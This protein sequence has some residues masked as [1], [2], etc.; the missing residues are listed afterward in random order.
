LPNASFGLRALDVH[1][2]PSSVLMQ[3]SA[4]RTGLLAGARDTRDVRDVGRQLRITGR[5]V[6]R[7][8]ADTTSNVSRGSPP[9]R[10]SRR[11]STLGHEMLTST[12]AT[13]GAPSRMPLTSAYSCTVSAADV[14]QH[15][16]VVRGQRGADV[17]YERAHADALE[18]DRVQEP[19]G[20]LRRIRGV[21]QPSR[22]SR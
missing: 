22:G 1:R 4:S 20:R 13:P 9:E 14:H 21:A 19:G 18:P 7:R 3:E 12:P 16:G 8:T 11:V 5:R 10:D 2:R 15:G 17:A 6:A